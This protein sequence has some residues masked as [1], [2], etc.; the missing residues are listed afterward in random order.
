MTVRS[1]LLAVALVVVPGAGLAMALFPPRTMSLPARLGLVVPL[2]FAAVGLASLVLALM[3]LLSTPWL[4][5]GWAA[6]TVLS[7]AAALRRGLARHRT[8]WREEVRTN[9]APYAIGL[10]VLIAFAVTR[11]S[12]DPVLNL[13]DQTPLRYWADGIE[14]ADGGQVPG[15]SLQWGILAPAT[16]SKVVLNAFNGGA[17]LVLGRGP[18]EPMGGL[19]AVLSIGLLFTAFG[20]AWELGLRLTA[21]AV[22]VLLFGNGLIGPRDLTLDLVNYRAENWGRAVALGAVLVGVRAIREADPSSRRRLAVLAGVLFAV[23]AGTHLVAAAI[24]AAFLAMAALA[25]LLLD[26]HRH[27]L[28]TVGV[29]GLVAAVMGAALLLVTPGEAGFEGA[30]RTEAYRNLAADLGLEPTFDPTRYLALGQAVGPPSQDPFYDPPGAVYHEFVRRAVG[31][32]R[33]RR[34]LLVLFPLAMIG[35]AF[36]VWRWGRD[37][38]RVTA[39][40]SLAMAAVILATGLAFNYAYEV[41]VLAEFGPRRLFDYTGMAAVLLAAAVVETGFQ[42]LAARRRDGPRTAIV[43]A[44]VGTVALAALAL[45][46]TV[47]SE[48]RESFFASGLATLAWVKANVPCEGR[49]LADRRTLATF[50]LFTG[51]AGVLEGMGPYL[52]PDLLGVAIRELLDAEAFFADPVGGESYLRDRDVAAVVVTA[53]EQTLGGVGGPLRMSRLGLHGLNEVPFLE[54]VAVSETVAVYRVIGFEPDS[55]TP[56][57]A[58]LPGYVCDTRV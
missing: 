17:S 40:A 13:A 51:H 41:Y 1:V 31:E 49:I 14:I 28:S 52:R 53:Y 43:M 23:G 54:R 5:A 47:A 58:E 33:L 26:R 46:R 2:G 25:T 24:G 36:G 29:A 11:L 50:E 16:Q 45:P 42:R 55:A 56:N 7:W 22:P 12:Y 35:A 38:L 27:G 20:V 32:G 30:G 39:L 9:R 3:G 34:P 37:R 10:V 44:V 6:A 48:E 19:L 4:V 21:S 57:V 18:L 15:R 8:A